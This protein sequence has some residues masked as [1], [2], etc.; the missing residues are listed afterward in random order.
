MARNPE[1]ASFIAKRITG[2]KKVPELNQRKEIGHPGEDWAWQLSS[3][4]L[5][6]SS[7][8]V[9]RACQTKS[10]GWQ[11][12]NLQV[13]M[14]EGGLVLARSV[15]SLRPVHDSLLVARSS[16]KMAIPKQIWPISSSLSHLFMFEQLLLDWATK[17]GLWNPQLFAAQRNS[18]LNRFFKI[19]KVFVH[20]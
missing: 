10:R 19:Y 12:Y 5:T 11:T 6:F 4:P 1:L 16:R 9:C 15:I 7:Y 8:I 17:G 2:G 14:G 13:W 20:L 18:F 3:C